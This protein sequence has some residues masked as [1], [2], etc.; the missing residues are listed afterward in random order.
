M[1]ELTSSAKIELD[2]RDLLQ[3]VVNVYEYKN[4]CLATKDSLPERPASCAKICKQGC[5]RSGHCRTAFRCNH[6]YIFNA[7]RAYPQTSVT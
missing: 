1:T 5:A 2:E 4:K 7:L 6:D 3:A